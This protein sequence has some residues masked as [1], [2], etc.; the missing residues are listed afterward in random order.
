MKK[1]L[2]VLIAYILGACA[3]NLTPEQKMANFAKQC[4]D[5]GFKS[6]TDAYANC[7]MKLDVADTRSTQKSEQCS[8]VGAAAGANYYAAYSLCMAATD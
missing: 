6:N 4:Q 5:Y 3:V 1:L 2:I 7:V 8:S